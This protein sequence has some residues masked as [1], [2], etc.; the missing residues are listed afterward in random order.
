MRDDLPTREMQIV[1]I[2]YERG[3]ATAPEIEDALNGEVGNSAV[4]AMLSRLEAKGYVSRRKAD[5]TYV[6]APAVPAGQ[7][8]RSALQRVIKVFFNGS[9]AGAASALLGM[10][11][12]LKNEDLDALEAMIAKVRKERER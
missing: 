4:R 7:A 8:R 12:K 3:E 2:L 1:D 11:E 10:G 5:K 9:P 6:Y